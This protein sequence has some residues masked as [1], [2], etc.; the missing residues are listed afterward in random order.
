MHYENVY[1]CC[2]VARLCVAMVTICFCSSCLLLPYC[3]ENGKEF[4]DTNYFSPCFNLNVTLRMWNVCFL[5]DEL[6]SVIFLNFVFVLLKCSM[7]YVIILNVK[8]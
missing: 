4:N 7:I 2:S 3:S 6:S 8:I 1:I 5:Y